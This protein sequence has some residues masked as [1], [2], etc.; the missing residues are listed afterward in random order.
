[1]RQPEEAVELEVPELSEQV[2]LGRHG[3]ALAVLTELQTTQHLSSST[4]TEAQ[5]ESPHLEEQESLV[6]LIKQPLQTQAQAVPVDKCQT[7]QVETILAAEGV[8]P[9]HIS[10]RLFHRLVRLTLTL[11]DLVEVLERLEPEETP[12]ELAVAV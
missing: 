1:M 6:R 5:A 10:R 2:Q 4:Y 7:P 8:V 9:A 3:L 11:L 12:E